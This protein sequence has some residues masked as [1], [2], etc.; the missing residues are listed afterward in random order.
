MSHY[1]C[2]CLTSQVNCPGTESQLPQGDEYRENPS[3]FINC[4]TRLL[5]RHLKHVMKLGARCASFTVLYRDGNC[6]EIVELWNISCIIVELWNISCIIVELW[7][8]SCILV[9]L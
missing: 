2:V 9:E 7:N 6:W 1:H 4:I 5:A 8:I 3:N